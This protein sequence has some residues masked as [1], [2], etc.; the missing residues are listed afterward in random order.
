MIE[1]ETLD[2]RRQQQVKLESR[3]VEI[4]ILR[5]IYD[6]ASRGGR[7][8]SRGGIMMGGQPK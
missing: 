8:S 4:R 3:S 7:E 5:K 6:M 1:L 2:E